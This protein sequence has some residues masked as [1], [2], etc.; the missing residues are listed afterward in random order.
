M[1]IPPLFLF[2]VT[3]LCAR[4]LAKLTSTFSLFLFIYKFVCIFC[5][6]FVYVISF[7]ISLCYHDTSKDHVCA[8]GGNGL[9]K[10]LHP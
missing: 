5:M 10:R 9:G 3:F 8:Q 2:L 6:Y 1:T 7:R 4:G